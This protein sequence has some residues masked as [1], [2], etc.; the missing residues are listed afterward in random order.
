MPIQLSRRQWMLAT[1]I[2]SASTGS[3]RAETPEDTLAQV[4]REWLPITSRSI[5]LTD[6][7][8]KPPVITAIA[9]DPRGELVAVAGDDHLIHILATVNLKPLAVLRGH[10]DRIRTLTFDPDGGKLAS[11]GNDG[12]LII[13]QRDASFRVQQQMS[14]TPSLACVRFSPEGDELAAVGFS[15]DVYVI[16]SMR[17][18]QEGFRCSEADLRAVAY[19]DDGRMLAVVGRSGDLRL[20]DVADRMQ[21]THPLHTGRIQDAIFHYNSPRVVCVG[22]DGR[23]SVFDTRKGKLMGQ[24]QV[25]TGKLFAI[26]VLNSQLVAVAG[27]DNLI[28]IV[29]TDDGTITRKLGGHSGTVS[30]LAAGG[31]LLFSGGYDT[32]LRR[33]SIHEI[34]ATGQRLAERNPSFDR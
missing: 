14:G 29:N 31:G 13:W 9:V 10:R 20:F 30:A 4:D 32:T 15:Q 28:F 34:E 5:Q 16:G 18:N 25:T 2:G 12:E 7:P 6:P 33:W 8:T 27:S 26:T 22:E 23:L 21:S 24:L 3:V 1:V 19:R 17:N 11:G